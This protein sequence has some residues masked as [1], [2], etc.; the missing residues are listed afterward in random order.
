MSLAMLDR[1]LRPAAELFA[2]RPCGTRHR[3]LAGCRCLKCRMAASNYE[4]ARARARRAGE[5]NGLVD[6]GP[7]R[8]HILKLSRAGVGYKLVADSASVARSIVAKVKSGERRQIRALSAKRIL[9]VTTDCR[10]DSALVSAA[11]TWRLLRLLLDEGY[12]RRALAQMLGSTA[13]TPS[14]QIRRDRVTAR[15]AARVAALYRRLTT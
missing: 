5:W 14:L 12:T 15:T 13:R 4:T 6:A 10:G 7:A 2:D 8:Q 11:Q 3:Y 9:S 1:G